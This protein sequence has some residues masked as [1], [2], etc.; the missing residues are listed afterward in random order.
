[1]STMCSYHTWFYFHYTLCPWCQWCRIRK[2]NCWGLLCFV[3]Q[4]KFVRDFWVAEESLSARTNCAWVTGISQSTLISK[5]FQWPGESPGVQYCQRHFWVWAWKHLLTL[6]AMINY[7]WA[8]PGTGLLHLLV[9]NSLTQ[10]PQ[11]RQPAPVLHTATIK[12][13]FF[14]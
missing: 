2:R 8:L 4:F 13:P 5:S 1:M 14:T 7:P 6:A 12:N 11:S 3:F 9:K 10:M